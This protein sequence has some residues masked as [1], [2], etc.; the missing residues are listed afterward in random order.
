MLTAQ[1]HAQRAATLQ[2]LRAHSR[3]DQG[4]SAA[5][6]RARYADRLA[7][8]GMYADPGARAAARA[9][10]ELEQA[11]ELEQLR[12]TSRAHEREVRAGVLQSL[13]ALHGAERRA[14]RTRQRHQRL[15]FAVTTGRLRRAV[16]ARCEARVAV[17]GPLSKRLTASRNV[18][19]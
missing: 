13:K 10:L 14:L 4:V 17:S 11:I 7:R 8:L 12:L 5:A 6:I 9:R 15:V 1:Q 18:R 19:R 2:D 16:G 3:S